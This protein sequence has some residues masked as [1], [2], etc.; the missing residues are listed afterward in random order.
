MPPEKFKQHMELQKSV[1]LETKK[2]TS[3]KD[4]ILS[5]HVA[6]TTCLSIP[7]GVQS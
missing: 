4:R 2:S 7:L 5:P 1:T 6:L 3:F